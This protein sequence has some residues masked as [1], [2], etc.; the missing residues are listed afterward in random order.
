M[1]NLADDV[2]Q[3]LAVVK[4]L[5]HGRVVHINQSTGQILRH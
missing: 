4:I 5:F 1:T 3:R 2:K